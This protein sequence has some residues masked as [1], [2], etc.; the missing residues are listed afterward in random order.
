MGSDVFIGLR[1]SVSKFLFGA[2]LSYHL[3]PACVRYMWKPIVLESESSAHLFFPAKTSAT[4]SASCEC[5]SHFED[6]E[7]QRS[8]R[9]P[10]MHAGPVR[11]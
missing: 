1:I 8:I 4:L 10:S 5:L 3:K 11:A 2:V 6:L 7:Y 9:K